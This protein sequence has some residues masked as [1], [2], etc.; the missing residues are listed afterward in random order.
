VTAPILRVTLSL[1]FVVAA[2][3]A[4]DPDPAGRP[5][6]TLKE[7]IVRAREIPAASLHQ[8]LRDESILANTFPGGISFDDAVKTAKAAK[9]PLLDGWC[10]GSAI[11]RRYKLKNSVFK[12]ADGRTADAYLF[13][14]ALNKKEGGS[15]FATKVRFIEIGLLVHVGLTYQETIDQKI[16]ADGTA[17]RR[18]LELGEVKEAGASWPLIDRILIDYRRDFNAWME[19]NPSGFHFETKFVASQTKDLGD[20]N[21]HGFIASGLDPDRNWKG[22]PAP[23]KFTE[24]DTLGDPDYQGGSYTELPEELKLKPNT[25]PTGVT[26]EKK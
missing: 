18:S 19:F 14:R 6:R 22:K 25:A 2:S 20:N 16:F 23:G 5:S 21:I 13:F 11:L 3:H 10:N 15:P 1:L 26:V 24:E 17:L 8:W 4:K 7:V 9:L 12:F